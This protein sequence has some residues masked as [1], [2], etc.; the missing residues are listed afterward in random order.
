MKKIRRLTLFFIFLSAIS[1]SNV[2]GQSLA[3]NDNVFGTLDENGSLTIYPGD[4]LEGGPYDFSL[5]QIFNQETGEGGDFLTVDC[6]D[7]GTF[8]IEVVDTTSEIFCWGYLTVE[9]KLGPMTIVSDFTIDLDSESDTYTLLVN[10][11][12]EGSYDNCSDITYSLSRTEFSID[13]WGQTQVIL[14]TTDASQNTSQ[15]MSVITVL[16]DGESTPMQCISISTVFPSSFG[17]DLE[18]WAIDFVENSEDFDNVLASLDPAGPFSESFVASCGINGDNTYTVYIE[19]I[20]NQQEYNCESELTII[21]NSPPVAISDQTVWLYLQDGEA[22]LTLEMVDDGSYDNCTDVLLSLNKTH[23]TT[24]DVGMN[25]VVL[26]VT[27]L[28]GNTNMVSSTV[29]VDDGSWCNLEYTVILPGPIEIF[30]ENGTESN[31]SIENLQSIYGYDYGDVHPITVHECEGIVYAYED[32]VIPITHGLEVL[33]TWTI[34]DWNIGDVKTYVQILILYTSYSSMLVCNDMEMVYT[35]YGSVTL[36]PNDVLEGGPYNYDNMVLTLKDSNDDIIVDNLITEDYVG[37]QLIYTVTD[38]TTGNSCFGYIEVDDTPYECPLEDEYIN[39]PLPSIQI[40]DYDLDPSILTPDYLVSNYGFDTSEVIITWWPNN[41]C[42]VVGYTHQDEV[43]FY[44]DGR[45]QIVRKLTTIDW[46]S[47]EP[48]STDVGIWTFT[49]VISAGIDAASLICDVLPRTADVGDCESGHTLDDDVEWPADLEIADYRISPAELVE[50]SMVDVLDSEPSFYNNPD[51]YEASKIDLLVDINASTLVLGRVWTVTNTLYNFTWTYTQTITIDFFGFDN[52]VTVNTGTN[53]AMSGVMINE[54]FS[55]NMQGDAYV[56]GQPVNS[57]Q[58]EDDYL[59]GVNILDLILIQRHILG[60]QSLAEYAQLAADVNHDN[61]IEA[62]D[63]SE[64]RDKIIRAVPV[65]I[66][67]W[68]FY[69]KEIE[70]PITIEPKGVFVGVKSGDVDDSALLEGEDSLDPIS[71]FEVIDILLNKGESYSVPIY[72]NDRTGAYGVE[73]RANIDNDLIEIIDITSAYAVHDFD[74]Y[75][76]EDGV[77][78]FIFHSVGESYEIGGQS[79]DP[80]FT[81]DIEA[82]ENSLLSLALDLENHQS[83]IASSALELI[84]LGGEID[85]MIGTGTNSEELSNLSVYPNP[86]SDYLNIDLKNVD[87]NG[88]V[89]ISVYELNGQKLF[90]RFDDTRIDISELKS[91]MY[92]YQVKIET[93]TT[94]GKFVVIK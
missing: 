56:E 73:F 70:S 75:I 27:D 5:I 66:G 67:D 64:L 18:L 90:S 21:D 6:D 29:I 91:G 81:I 11:I 71:K 15:A 68:R 44:E 83:Y 77:L 35:Y 26:T 28:N 74:Y 49:Q 59:N 46:L 12:N 7:I 2:F 54:A 1:I 16:V 38:T 55:T 45:F 60:L 34:L 25:T 43:L 80:V 42:G 24:N 79:S 48:P 62:S 65:D 72:L 82:K 13:D 39:Y 53:R 78:T 50:F 36:A 33:R 4:I 84:V 47:Y 76:T 31:L 86:A 20:I 61:V 52:L 22:T 88:S 37:Q 41:G 51:D 63:L 14:T 85:D 93:Y 69:D 57:I 40:A 87:V 3:C 9:D 17:S 94:T 92:Y 23:F 19:G 58:Y 89:E 32:E 10:D 8:P 30:D